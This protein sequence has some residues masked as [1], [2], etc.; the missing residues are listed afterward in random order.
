MARPGWNCEKL[1]TPLPGSSAPNEIRCVK[2]LVYSAHP[3]H[4]SDHPKALHLRCGLLK[5]ARRCKA[6]ASLS[7]SF[8]LP[9]AWIVLSCSR[10]TSC[11]YRCREVL[12]TQHISTK[13]CLRIP[14]IASA[15]STICAKAH[16]CRCVFSF[17]SKKG[18]DH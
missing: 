5:A 16:F 3:F 13:L 4:L 11:Q 6:V 7:L 8:S 10:I 14:S 9:Q 15:S 12:G 17:Q 2:S 1:R 18:G